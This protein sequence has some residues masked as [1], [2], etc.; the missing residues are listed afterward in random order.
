MGRYANRREILIDGDMYRRVLSEKERKRITV[1]ATPTFPEKTA[2]FLQQLRP[3]RYVWRMSDNYYKVAH[4]VY[5]D[6]D[7]WWL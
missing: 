5:G 3:D 7:L 6:R 2:D 1:H 4:K